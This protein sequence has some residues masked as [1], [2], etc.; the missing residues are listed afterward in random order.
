MDFS[1]FNAEEQQEW[2]GSFDVLPD[3]DYVAVIDSTEEKPVKGKPGSS[4]LE[5][6]FQVTDGP[7]ANACLWTRLNLKNDS[8]KASNIARAELAAI[9]KAVGVLKP[10]RSEDLHD[11]PLTVRVRT[12]E[13]EDKPGQ[14]RNEIR[15]YMPYS[16]NGGSSAQPPSGGPAAPWEKNKKP[17]PF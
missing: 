12:S 16:R 7:H 3:D 4:Y 10:Q 11:I 1:G 8:E 2:K 6:R 17:T 5:V 14:F 13:R 15:G 9:C